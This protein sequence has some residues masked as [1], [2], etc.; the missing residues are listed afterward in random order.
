MVRLHCRIAG[1]EP[2]GGWTMP[3]LAVGA[4]SLLCRDALMFVRA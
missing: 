1:P 4:G 2:I 3:A